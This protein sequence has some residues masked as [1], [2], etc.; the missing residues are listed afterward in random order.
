CAS[1][2]TWAPSPASSRSHRSCRRS[3]APRG[4]SRP[5]TSRWSPSACSSPRARSGSPTACCRAPGR[6]CSPTSGWSRSTA[7]SSSRSCG[8]G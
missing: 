1:P 8:T 5:G 6:W 3:W 4:R 2:S 7:R